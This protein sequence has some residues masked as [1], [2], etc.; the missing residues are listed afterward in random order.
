M[1][2]YLAVLDDKVRNDGEN[3]S[4]GIIICKGKNKTIVEYALRSTK[5][6]IGVANY[7]LS[8]TLP[9]EYKNL[10]PSPGE[11]K[12]KLSGFIDNLESDLKKH[13]YQSKIAENNIL[14]AVTP[15]QQGEISH[16][17]N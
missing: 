14:I 15:T 6:P 4:I 2:F 8:E 3:P 16:K 7:T 12:E 9:V 5:G 11:I 10:L 1:N 13:N 17:F